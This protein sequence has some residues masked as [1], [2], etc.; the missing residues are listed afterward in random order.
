[1]YTLDLFIKFRVYTEHDYCMTAT[2]LKRK[3]DQLNLKYN[4]CQKVIDSKNAKIRRI[5]EKNVKLKK[6]LETALDNDNADELTRDRFSKL[7][8]NV[9]LNK[10]I[11]Q[12]GKKQ[13]YDD[14][15]IRRFA[16]NLHF[17]SPKEW[18]LYD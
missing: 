16:L 18:N 15:D 13:N 10:L 11:L 5:D 1:M 2:N 4:K 14:K 8:D 7:A 12:E 6:A 3:Y 17:Y 9:M